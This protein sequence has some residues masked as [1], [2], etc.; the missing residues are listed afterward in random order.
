MEIC[1]MHIQGTKLPLHHIPKMLLL[2]AIL[3]QWTHCHVQ[4]TNFKWFE[5]CDMVHYPPGSSHQRMGTWCP[6]MDGHGQ[7]QCS[8]RLWHL[9]D[10]QLSLRGLSVPRKHPPHHYNTT[11]SLHSGNKAWW[12][13]VLILFTKFW[14]YH[15]NVSA[16]IETHQTRQ[17]FSSLQLSNFAEL[18]Q[19]V[20]SFSY[21]FLIIL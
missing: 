3:V 12:I 8:S 1:G 11:T 21:L 18:L 13:H 14:L 7:K 4:K 20:A 9:N 19:I 16:E 17:H 10:A 15:Q 5:L 2:E 6:L